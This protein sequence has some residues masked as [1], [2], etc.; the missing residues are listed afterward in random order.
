MRLPRGDLGLLARFSI[1]PVSSYAAK[2]QI[3]PA[4]AVQ[5]NAP[6]GSIASTLSRQH[7]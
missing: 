1:L 4:A 2:N 7:W 6:S 3:I 5:R